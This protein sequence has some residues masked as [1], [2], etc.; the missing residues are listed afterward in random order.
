MGQSPKHG[1]NLHG[2]LLFL[3]LVT[4]FHSSI[5]IPVGMGCM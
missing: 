5:P 1:F 2:G 4:G 3:A